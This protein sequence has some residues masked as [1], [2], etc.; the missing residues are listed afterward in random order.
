VLGSSGSATVEVR[1]GGTWRH[2]G[3]FRN[4]YADLPAGGAPVDA[5]RLTWDSGSP[6]PSVSEVV[7]VPA[8]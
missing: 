4:G 2:I 8:G 1:A 3:T 7:P 6:A 5:V